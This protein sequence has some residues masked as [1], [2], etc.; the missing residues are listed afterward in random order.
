MKKLIAATVI[1]GGLLLGGAGIAA[2]DT[3]INTGSKAPNFNGS[4]KYLKY[5]TCLENAAGEY[6]PGPQVLITCEQG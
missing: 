4:Y 3:T 2:A 6:G 5:G 1:S